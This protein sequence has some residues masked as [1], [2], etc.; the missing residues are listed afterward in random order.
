MSNGGGVFLVYIKL[1]SFLEDV[2]VLFE[3]LLGKL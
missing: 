2:L 3:S 1:C